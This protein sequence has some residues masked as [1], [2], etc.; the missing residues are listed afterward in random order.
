M[1]DMA[2]RRR[3]LD[4]HASGLTFSHVS[5]ATGISRFAIRGWASGAVPSPRMSAECPVRDGQLDPS[6][7]RAD[8][9]YLLGLYLGDGCISEGRRQVHALRIACCNAWPGLIL[10]CEQAVAAVLPHNK[11]L[12]VRAPGCPKHLRPISLAPRQQ[13]IVDAHPWEFLRGL[14][15]SDVHWK[16][17]SRSNGAANISVAR[18]DSVAL[19][20]AHIGPKC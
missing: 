13:E 17:A 6:R 3:A 12:R 15:H 4:L 2:T 1:Y 14:I 16:A 18:K 9:A 7:P 10:E 8:Y 11:V 19:M 20:D 5:R